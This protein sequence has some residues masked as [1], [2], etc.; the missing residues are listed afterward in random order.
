VFFAGLLILV[1]SLSVAAG[2][3]I[4]RIAGTVLEGWISVMISVW[5]LGGLAIFCIGVVGL[6]VSRIFIETKGRPYTIIRQMHQYVPRDER[7]S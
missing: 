2:L 6:Y 3:V 1:M 5:L 7:K 4:L